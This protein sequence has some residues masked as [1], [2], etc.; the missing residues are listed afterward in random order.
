[1]ITFMEKGNRQHRERFNR[2][3]G[4]G[5]GMLSINSSDIISLLINIHQIFLFVDFIFIFIWLHWVLVAAGGIWFPNQRSNLAPLHWEHR[6]SPGTN[7]E[8]P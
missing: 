2:S 3:H 6:V 4:K 7:R 5:I 1:M 8:V